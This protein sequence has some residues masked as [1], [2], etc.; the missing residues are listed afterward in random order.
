M[1]ENDRDVVKML[2]R[3]AADRL[4]KEAGQRQYWLLK[5]GTRDTCSLERY[6]LACWLLLFICLLLAFALKAKETRTSVCGV[7]AS[8]TSHCIGSALETY[9]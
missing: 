4:V 7:N 8:S 1:K 2:R 5:P 9:T 3:S 6:S